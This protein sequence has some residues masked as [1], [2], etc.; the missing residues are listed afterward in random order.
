MVF[1]L[2]FRLEGALEPG[3][4]GGAAGEGVRVP[5]GLL[6]TQIPRPARQ[7]SSPCLSSCTQSPPVGAAAPQGVPVSLLFCALRSQRCS[8]QS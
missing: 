8:L 1:V 7:V 6:Q 3:G 4:G 5:R 2:V